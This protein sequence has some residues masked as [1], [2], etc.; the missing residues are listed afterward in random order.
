[1]AKVLKVSGHEAIHV[2][3]ANLAQS[4]DDEIWNQAA[5]L[6]AVILTKDEDFADRVVRGLAGVSVVWI[7]I[8][9]CPNRVLLKSF[10]DA[11][12]LIVQKLESGERLI[13]I[14]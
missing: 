12:P 14:F 3:E 8:G 10:A 13:E 5:N 7:R 2:L 6:Q 4:S 1:M 9:N 11:M